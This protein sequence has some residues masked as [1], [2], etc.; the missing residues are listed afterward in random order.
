MNAEKLKEKVR[1][2]YVKFEFHDRDQLQNTKLKEDV[3]LFD[4]AKAIA[5]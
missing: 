4:I 3:Q 5:E 1:S 2:N